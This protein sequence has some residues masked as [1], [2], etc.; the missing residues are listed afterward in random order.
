VSW[1]AV[2]PYHSTRTMCRTAIHAPGLKKTRFFSF[3]I[4]DLAQSF[5]TY[6]TCSCRYSCTVCRTTTVERHRHIRQSQTRAQAAI[7]IRPHRTH[8]AHAHSTPDIETAPRESSAHSCSVRAGVARRAPWKQTRPQINFG[9]PHTR[10]QLAPVGTPFHHH[11]CPQSITTSAPVARAH[12]VTSFR[13]TAL[14]IC[15]ARAPPRSLLHSLPPRSHPQ[16][17]ARG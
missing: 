15:A 10:T 1:Y 17:G 14:I 12:M 9:G 6:S 16:I 4:F 7:Y 8:T 11:L 13:N 2:P 5:Y 3:S